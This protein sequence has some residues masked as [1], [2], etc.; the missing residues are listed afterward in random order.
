MAHQ[1]DNEMTS[2]LIALV[3]GSIYSKSVC[4]HAAWLAQR[5]GA[6]VQILHVLG[7]REV[8]VADFSGAIALGARSALLAELG[9]LDA[10]RA[11]L[12]QQ[13][14]RAILEDAQAIVSGAGAG[15]VRRA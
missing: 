1:E 14:G 2:T 8:P 4:D 7:R 13:K 12:V 9:A 3:D 10:Q 11:K 15:T 6:A 5:T